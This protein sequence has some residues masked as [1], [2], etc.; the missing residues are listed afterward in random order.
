MKFAADHVSDTYVVLTIN[1]FEV[2]VS[3]NEDGILVQIGKD[4][5]VQTET[6]FG[7]DEKARKRLTA[8]R[9]RWHVWR[10]L[11][12]PLP[13]DTPPASTSGAAA[14]L[15]SFGRAGRSNS[16][17]S[18]ARVRRSL[19]RRR[20]VVQTRRRGFLPVRRE[21]RPRRAA[22]GVRPFPVLSVFLRLRLP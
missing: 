22:F 16:S 4:G 3:A 18:A 2:A 1:G 12:Y 17:R 20:R 11:F 5:I 10:G 13:I 8:Y 6:G 9:P 7:W 15:G 19:S 14:G 21:L